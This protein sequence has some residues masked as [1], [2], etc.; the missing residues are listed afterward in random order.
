VVTCRRNSANSKARLKRY[1]HNRDPPMTTRRSYLLLFV[2]QASCVAVGLV[3]HELL[4]ARIAGDAKTA[5]S[6][7]SL[8]WAAG[9]ITFVWTAG[10]LAVTLFMM[11]GYF[12]R[13]PSN[14]SVN[15]EIEALRQAQALVRTQET[16]IFGLAK[17]SD[18]RDPD[19]GSHLERIAQ[20]SSMLA[21][22][23]R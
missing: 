22:A 8:L 11:A 10:L 15:P 1:F 2:V 19:T 16:V 7:G 23:L 14:R 13:D 21:A 9:G 17:L 18:S 20:F 12:K 6:P 4:F 5:A 3:F